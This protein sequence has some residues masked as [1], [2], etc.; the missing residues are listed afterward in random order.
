MRTFQ[1]TIYAGAALIAAPLVPFLLFRIA[2]AA[3]PKWLALCAG[4][5]LALIPIEI[6]L[7]LV[8]FNTA[9]LR[10]LF[11]AIRKRSRGE[12]VKA[13]LILPVGNLLVG[14]V[15]LLAIKVFWLGGVFAFPA[16]R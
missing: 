5:G 2:G 12:L 14:Y 16:P 13:C 15:L 3:L 8:Y 10:S 9:L 4:F 1:R 6:A 7:F 11:K